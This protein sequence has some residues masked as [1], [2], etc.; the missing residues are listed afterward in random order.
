[1][2]SHLDQVWSARL[3]INESRAPTLDVVRVLAELGRIR[4]LNLVSEDT[5]RCRRVPVDRQ[6]VVARDPLGANVGVHLDCVSG[7]VGRGCSI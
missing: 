7:P 5:P 1:M 2:P 3:R 6:A 4:E